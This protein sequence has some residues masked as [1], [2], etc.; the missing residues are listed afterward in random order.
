MTVTAKPAWKFTGTESRRCSAQALRRVQSE[1]SIKQ[2]TQGKL[3]RTSKSAAKSTFLSRRSINASV[4]GSPNR[5]LYSKT[6]GPDGVSMKPVKSIPRKGYP[7][8]SQS[9]LESMISCSDMGIPSFR[10]PSM[11][12][13]NTSFIIPFNISD[14][15]T[16]AGT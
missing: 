5:T 11:V 2:R 12:G 7:T 15:A 1:R 4:S 14:V 13:L 8:Q 10:I 6:F 9:Q 16:G 3:E